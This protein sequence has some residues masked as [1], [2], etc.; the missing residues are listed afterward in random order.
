MSFVSSIPLIGGALSAGASLIGGNSANDAAASN[1][2]QQMAFQERMSSTAHQREVTDLRAAGLNPIL[3]A[4][5]SGAS[6]PGGSAA[7]VLNALGD[8]ARQGITDWSAMKQTTALTEKAK[9]EADLA[10]VNA[11]SV[12][13]N[14]GR[15]NPDIALTQADISL[16][17]GGWAARTFGTSATDAVRDKLTD[18]VSGITTNSARKVNPKV[19]GSGVRDFSGFR[20]VLPDG[21][22]SNW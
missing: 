20:D 8:A 16:K 5:G 11:L 7:P 15:V 9:A 10:K 17:R 2:D 13:A 21:S 19:H 3:S 22:S 14:M 1:S 12:A 18:V 6:T 4:G